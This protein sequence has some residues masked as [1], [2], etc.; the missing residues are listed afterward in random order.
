MSCVGKLCL[1]L[2]TSLVATEWSF[3][4]QALILKA[5]MNRKRLSL[6]SYSKAV[7]L[8]PSHLSEQD[9]ENN[10][11]AGIRYLQIRISD[12]ADVLFSAM[13]HWTL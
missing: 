5:I 2:R 6:V 11:S 12:R 4:H 3:Q 9:W 13:L 1:L 7:L 10:I 8:G